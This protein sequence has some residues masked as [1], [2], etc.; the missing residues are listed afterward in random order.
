MKLECEGRVLAAGGTVIRLTNLYGPGQSDESVLSRILQQIPGTGPLLVRTVS[1]VR[2]FCWVGDAAQAAL[3]LA[4]GRVSGIF[5]VGHG[6]SLSIGDL[7][8]TALEVAGEAGRSVEPEVPDGLPSVLAVDISETSKACG[9]V[10]HMSLADGI[11]RIMM[12][13]K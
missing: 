5:N 4:A 11:R 12:D 3:D 10:P 9:W 13:S 6:K 8:S 7:A 1:P 2:D